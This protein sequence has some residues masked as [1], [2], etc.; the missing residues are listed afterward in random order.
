MTIYVLLNFQTSGH[1]VT[2]LNGTL[3]YACNLKNHWNVFC[4]TCVL[5]FHFSVVLWWILDPIHKEM[6]AA[7]FYCSCPSPS[8]IV[9]QNDFIG[10]LKFYQVKFMLWSLYLAYLLPAAYKL[11]DCNLTHIY[12]I[13]SPKFNQLGLL[14]WSLSLL[15]V[16]YLLYYSELISTE[17]VLFL[18]EIW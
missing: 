2:T 4:K 9:V 16:A 5:A 7:A 18:T 13:G 14:C 3:L 15:S 17:L 8:S 6:L 10:S 11:S 12:F 1:F